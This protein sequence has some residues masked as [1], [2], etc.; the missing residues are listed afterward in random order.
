MAVA[1]EMTKVHE[2]CLIF[3]LSAW[4]EQVQN[5]KGEF[6][7]VL[8]PMEETAEEAAD[9]RTLREQVEELMQSGMEKKEAIKAVAKKNN[10]AKNDVYQETMDL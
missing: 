8:G 4:R 2:E 1:R 5:I 3:P 10:L 7:L 9:E 6:V